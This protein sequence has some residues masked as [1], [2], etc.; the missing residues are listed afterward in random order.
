MLLQPMTLIRRRNYLAAATVLLL[1]AAGL[2]YF[3]LQILD[4]D[5]YR[6]H[7]ERNSIREVRLPAPRGMIFDRYGRFLV[8]NRPQ[9]SLA[10]IPA[11]VRQN[12]DDLAQLSRYLDINVDEMQQVV[13]EAD[14]PYRRFQ[15][16]TLFSNVSFT[17]RSYIEEHRLEFPGIIF[18]DE[19]IR[20][21]P[22]RARA[23]HII[24][25]LRVIAT[26]DFP[27]Y[28]REGYYMGD[29]VGAAGL[30]RQ[31]ERVLKGQEGFRYH[32][33]DNLLR[34]LGEVPN[35]PILRPIPGQDVHLA[36]DI[37]LQA[38]SERIM[39]GRR[40]ALLAME[41]NTGEIYAYVSV[42]DYVLA[43]FTGSIP[44]PLWEQWRDH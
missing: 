26:E 5:Q 37:E 3:Q 7:A 44:V 14:G 11:E 2:R 36:M 24:G 40:G 35:K 25:Y 32:L 22:S 18:L 1:G 16:V 21:Y 10:V 8:T 12:L 27:R 13:K 29:V 42:P 38:F 9:F 6:V 43:P 17:Q 41:P 28:R 39:E 31:Y 4:H 33:V 30:E 20:H 23:T 19:S 34:D 15:P